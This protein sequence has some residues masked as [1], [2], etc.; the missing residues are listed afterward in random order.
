MFARLLDIDRA[1]AG[2]QDARNGLFHPVC[3]QAKS[4]RI[5]K[6]HRGAENRAYWISDIFSGERW[7]GTMDGLKERRAGAKTGRGDQADGTDKGS[8]SIAED[9]AKHVG[10]EHNI[11]L[12]RPQA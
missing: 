10:A 11:E 1:I 4:K 6:H 9:I 2:A 12:G 5:A 8:G 7:S 3:F